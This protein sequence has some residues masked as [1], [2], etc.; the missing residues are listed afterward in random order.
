MKQKPPQLSPDFPNA[1]YRV[2]AKGICVR[3]GKVLMVHDFTGRSDTDDRPDW[4]LP[5]GGLDFEEN[6]TDALK[7]EI[8]EEMGLTVSWIEDRPRYAWSTKHGT[9]RGMEWYYVMTVIFRF[10]VVDLNFTP[11]EECREIRFFSKEELKANYED[12]AAQIKPLAE[13]FNPEDFT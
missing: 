13:K 4:E 8:K 9:G 11:T 3:D 5:G 2:T 6:F 10:D 7:R 1:F 12:L